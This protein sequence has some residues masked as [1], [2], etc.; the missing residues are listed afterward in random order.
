MGRAVRSLALALAA[1]VAAPAAAR[2]VGDRV[3]LDAT[4]PAH[5]VEVD[6]PP[7]AAG[8]RDRAEGEPGWRYLLLDR[9]TRLRGTVAETC[10]REV[11]AFDTDEGADAWGAWTA[12]WDP[13]SER[14]VLHRLEV[15]R[16]GTRV[17]RGAADDLSVETTPARHAALETGWRRVSVDLPEL[18]AGDVLDCVWSKAVSHPSFG[19]RHADEIDLASD[20]FV[21]RARVRLLHPPE[22]PLHAR[23]HGLDAPF[24]RARVG[25]DDEVTWD[26]RGIEPAPDEVGVPAWADVAPWLQVSSFGSWAEVAS[27]GLREVEPP[28]PAGPTV[29]ERADAI[30]HAHASEDARIVAALRLV[31]DEIAYTAMDLGSA[32]WRA[33][34]AGSTLAAG[35][36]D[37]KDKATLLAALLRTLGVEARLALTSLDLG[38]RVRRQLPSPLP[39]DHVLV[40]VRA[41]G[42]EWWLDPTLEGQRGS[43][44]RLECPTTGVALVLEPGAEDLMELRC[45]GPDVSR[46]EITSTYTLGRFADGA[47]LVVDTVYRGREADAVRG[48]A[49]AERA[50][51]MR[52]EYLDFYSRWHPRLRALQSPEVEDD[53]VT[54]TLRTRERYAIEGIWI[55]AGRGVRA[56]LLHRPE[57]EVVLPDLER[58]ARPRALPFEL[59]YPHRVVHRLVV[60]GRGD[61]EPPPDVVIRS[62]G[63]ELGVR[64]RRHPGGA[65]VVAD[66]RTRADH[67]PAEAYADHVAALAKAKSAL[68]VTV[69]AER[70]LAPRRR[71]LPVRL[72]A[73]WAGSAAAALLA[74]AWLA[75][76][77][78]RHGS[79]A[80][81]AAALGSRG[82]G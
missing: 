58:P 76:R 14:L 21:E 31:Q 36:G 77:T 19:G 79:Q 3:R 42:R 56:A 41:A 29:A 30:R 61:F 68:G 15:R 66:Y 12:D 11:V 34:P 81:P 27:W 80:G 82:P 43:L 1:V 32:A 13:G 39:F 7:A 51:E 5:V 63:L 9:Q 78:S 64:A 18:R 46:I 8:R 38:A 40:L 25:G 69:R 45:P 57:I 59:P 20:A 28:G 54:D 4:L 70:D 67:V 75:V 47:T 2:E 60:R 26:L 71:A 44:E 33:R 48:L 35:E 10:F 24:A 49:S 55:D 52:E 53:E 50:G 37:C 16:D 74:V 23:L 73:S 65:V 62:A 17:W 6:P 22:R 72:L